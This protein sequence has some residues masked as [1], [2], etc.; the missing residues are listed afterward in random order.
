MPPSILSGNPAFAQLKFLYENDIK[1]RVMYVLHAHI[2]W[3][4][5]LV[6]MVVTRYRGV[7]TKMKLCNFDTIATT[8]LLA[9]QQG[10]QWACTYLAADDVARPL[11]AEF[12]GLFVHQAL[13]VSL[14]ANV[15]FG[16]GCGLVGS[17]A[18][19]VY[20]VRNLTNKGMQNTIILSKNTSVYSHVINY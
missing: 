12:S 4:S 7:K 8:I 1:I 10:T 17:V 19:T 9:R 5:S 20:G 16:W 13:I 3:C 14:L 15:L 18:M 6:S 2:G 11:G